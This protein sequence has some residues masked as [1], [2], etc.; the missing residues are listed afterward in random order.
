M[1]VGHMVRRASGTNRRGQPPWTLVEEVRQG[2]V[3]L[4]T[5]QG[6]K[7]ATFIVRWLSGDERSRVWA[8]YGIIEDVEALYVTDQDDL[9]IPAWEMPP[10][11]SSGLIRPW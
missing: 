9:V 10:H 1:V 6:A 8:R 2:W 7:P 4:E 11:R 3:E 5:E